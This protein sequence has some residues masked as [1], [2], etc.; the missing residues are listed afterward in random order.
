[1][2]YRV[3][4]SL[5]AAEFTEL[6][7]LAVSVSGA[8]E[9]FQID[10]VDGRFAPHT[11]WPFSEVHDE[12]SVISELEKAVVVTEQFSTGFDCMIRDPHRFFATFATLGAKRVIIHY[13]ST[14]SM[15]DCVKMAAQYPFKL[16]LAVLNDHNRDEWSKLIPQ[17]AFIQVMG[18]KNV[19][20]QGQPFDERT[21]D[22]ASWLRMN[23][24]MLDIGIDGSVNADTIAALQR[25][26]AN[27]FAPGS[28]VSRANNPKTALRELSELI[29]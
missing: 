27:W 26:G 14:D 18:I 1:M 22:T 10:L 2:D 25:A 5:P 12:A 17:V 16:G 24:P 9:Y 3:Y 28:A 7:Q 4:P 15:E 8:T 13:G 21:L 11:S 29:Q 6:E 23:Y 20:V 19:G